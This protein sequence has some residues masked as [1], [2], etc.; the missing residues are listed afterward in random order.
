MKIKRLLAISL[1][2]IVSSFS[3][4]QGYL[5]FFQLRDIVPQTQNLQPAFIPDNSFTISLIPT[6][7]VNIQGDWTLEEI[8]SRPAGQAELRVDFDV[9]NAATLESNYLSINATVNLMH[10]GIKT[11]VG[12]VSLFANLKSNFDFNYNEDLIEFLAN[13]TSNYVGETIDF[14]GNRIKYE[15]FHE[16]GIGYVHKFLCKRLTVGTRIKRVT[17]MFHASI[18]ER[19]IGTLATDATDFVWTVNLENASA[20]TAGLDYLFN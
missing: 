4:G 1:L 16:I 2:A 9:L 19:A 6:V 7:G 12:A 5:S 14:S 3:Y 20:N 15:A 10:I 8:L 18:Q 13:W 17:G 11:K